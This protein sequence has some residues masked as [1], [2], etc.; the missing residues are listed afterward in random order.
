VAGDG[1]LIGI[2]HDLQRIADL[3]DVHALCEPDVFFTAVESA[4]IEAG[5]F[6]AQT[7]AAYF[8]AKEAL[9]KALG[10]RIDAYWT[11]LEIVHDRHGAPSFRLHRALGAMFEQRGWRAD[12]SISHS[13]EYASAFVTV[14]ASRGAF[15]MD[16]PSDEAPLSCELASRELAS[17]ELDLLAPVVVTVAM[18]PRDID[19]NQHVNNAVIV[20]Y[21]EIGRAAW[22]EKA[23]ARGTHD[24]LVFLARIEVDYLREI[25]RGAVMTLTT[26]LLELPSE[27]SYRARFQ[28]VL[29]VTMNG[30]GEPQVAVDARFEAVFVGAE[31][32]S[33]R[34][35]EDYLPR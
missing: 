32:R 17:R 12:L 18:R 6:P 33:L 14:S 21:L 10:G 16:V 7:R 24:I 28:Q 22:F 27:S 13:G 20:E 34:R 29:E 30:G 3:A 19:G 25:R 11:D 8:A 26:R 1:R 5:V 31:D 2:G 4:R 35:F 15:D 9:F 23:C